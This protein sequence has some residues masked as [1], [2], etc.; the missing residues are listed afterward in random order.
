MTHPHFTPYTPYQLLDLLPDHLET[1][2]E[3]EELASI[4]NEKE[5]LF[6]PE[7]VQSYA[8]PTEAFIDLYPHD[9]DEYKQSVCDSYGILFTNFSELYEEWLQARNVIILSNNKTLDL[10]L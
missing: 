7:A 8:T 9:I 10:D 4:L 3:A 5:A 2:E 1:I 6:D